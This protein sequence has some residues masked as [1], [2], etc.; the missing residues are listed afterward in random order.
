M[1]SR[2]GTRATR[3]APSLYPAPER[4]APLPTRPADM[5]PLHENLPQQSLAR[6]ASSRDNNFNL[7]RFIAATAVLFS[8]SFALSSGDKRTEPLSQSL[9]ITFGAIA[10]DVFFL[11]SGFLITAS[12]LARKELRSFV[13]A[14]VLRIYPALVVAVLLTVLVVGFGFTSL[15][16][17]AF[18]GHAETWVYLARTSTLVTG[19]A[20]TLPGGFEHAPLPHAVNASL[21][22]LPYEIA[23]YAML[24]LVWLGVA[25]LRADAARW[26]PRAIVALALTAMMLHLADQS[27][28]PK[29]AVRLVAMFFTGAAF[30]VYRAK[31][32]LD[33]R[34]FAVAFLAI[35]LAGLSRPLF[36]I[37]YPLALPYVV[38][39][40]AYLPGGVLRRFNRMG[41]YSYGI[42]VY[43]WPVQQ[44]IASLVPHISAG[45]MLAASFVATGAMA[46]AS[47]HLVEKSALQ[48]KRPRQL[49][50]A[51]AR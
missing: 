50:P 4:P 1:P 5:N 51:G 24:V 35:L 48:W 11:T 8:H 19:V 40:A 49:G 15:A 28:L 14:R 47:W 20:H 13:I 39:C 6:F 36:V 26:L 10:V 3:L 30:Y 31:I 7:I 17:T 34:V 16:P 37:V 21:W 22:T 2:P 45:A 12:L 25:A 23:M 42:Y 38:F 43:A 46:A 27:L 41:D 9:G 29:N 44:V 18:F 33:A 32:V